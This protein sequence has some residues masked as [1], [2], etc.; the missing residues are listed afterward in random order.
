VRRDVS[1]RLGNLRALVSSSRQEPSARPRREK[2][3]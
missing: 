2:S 3:P 1:P